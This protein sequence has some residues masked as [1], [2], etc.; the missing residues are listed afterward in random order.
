[1]RPNPS[2]CQ[3]LKQAAEILHKASGHVREGDD[4]ETEEC[5]EASYIEGSIIR[6]LEKVEQ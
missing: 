5:R 4:I 6:W 3:I 1:M 2:E